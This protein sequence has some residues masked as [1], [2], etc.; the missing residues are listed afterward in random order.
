MEFIILK[1]QSL[2]SLQWCYRYLSLMVMGGWVVG[3]EGFSL[4]Y[5]SKFSC[6][7]EIFRP[8]PVILKAEDLA[9][10]LNWIPFTQEWFVSVGLNE[11]GLQGLHGEKDFFFYFDSVTVYFK[12][13]YSYYLP[14]EKGLR[15]HLNNNA[16]IFI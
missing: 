14:A 1:Y 15:F 16:F 10:Y 4:Y 5:D 11:I 8:S 2:L 3:W 7:S 13:L 9:F 12:S 6:K